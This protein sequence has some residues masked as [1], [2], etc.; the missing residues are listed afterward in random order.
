MHF[1]NRQS[2]DRIS[3]QC[4]L[5][6]SLG[7][8][9]CS[10]VKA[11]EAPPSSELETI[12]VFAQ[13]PL[14]TRRSDAFRSTANGQSLSAD[15]LSEPGRHAMGNALEKLGG[16][17]ASDATG[18]PFQPDWF[19]R[20]YS[21]SPLLG[22]PQGL[23][24]YQD[25]VRVNE[26]FGDVV[27][28]D[29]IPLVALRSADLI[30]GS[31]PV[32]GRNTLAGALSL[33]TKSGFDSPGLTMELSGGE[34]GRRGGSMEYGLAGERAAL[35]IAADTFAEDG[36]RDYSNSRVARG[37]VRGS[38]LPDDRSTLD[39]SFSGAH[40]RLRGN[41]AAPR[42]LLEQE[43]RDAVFTYPDQTEPDLAFVNLTGTRALENGARLSGNA[44]YR[45]SLTRA[46]NGDG[47]EFEECEDPANVS[48]GG[49]PYL[50]EAEDDEEEVVTD[51]DLDPVVASLDNDS[52]TQNRSR[53]QQD[54]HGLSMQIERT[55]G[56]HSLLAGL[57]ADFGDVH[58]TSDTELGRLTAQRGTVG[59]GIYVAES[60]VNVRADN[61]SQGLYL[62]DVWRLSE[63]MQI[64]AA[65]RWNRTV[66]ELKDQM[67]D[68]DLSGKH[69]FN[70]INP[71][72]GA[73]YEL[74]PNWIVFGS[75][76]QSTR[77]P[78]PVELTCANPDD[79]CRLPN[80]FVDDPPLDEVV[81]HTFE[82]G[83]RQA[84]PTWSGSVALFSALSRDDIIFITNGDLTN[85]GYF[86]N[87]GRTLRQGFEM[88]LEWTLSAHWQA[89]LQYTALMAEFRDAFLVNAPNH[90]L[91][92]ASG[93]A[94]PST[95]IVRRG[96]R[97]PLIPRQQG[98]LALEWSDNRFEFGAEMLGRSNSRFRG[99]ES[100]LD[101]DQLS[102]FVLVNINAAWKPTKLVTFF[103]S[104]DNLF[105]RD[106]ETFG[107]Y[108]EG[109]EVLGD[110]FEDA[111]RFVGAGNP[112]SVQGGVRLR[113]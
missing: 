84:N 35:Y 13:S 88:G 6:M 46:F 60:L 90:P 44:Y 73:T 104:V 89:S 82:L 37:F 76:A 100:N 32:F 107:V 63:A 83:L 33:T 53:T 70:R 7:A 29:L 11:A 75:A 93:E 112:V 2:F 98:R 68:G 20:G 8:L 81:T 101:N 91:R 105:D 102:G 61:D 92:D 41:G 65:A 9:A 23:A 17:F 16:V 86:D 15:D 62:M 27:N 56:Q 48:A 108:G 71:M 10:S 94:D 30:P 58:F 99:D 95:Q 4:G 77:A 51:L 42:E 55:F 85:A 113:F 80:G 66:I 14:D 103:A 12:E 1:I 36:W 19:Y 3:R 47:T 67:P 5:L 26:A 50:C 18:S 97:I 49:D 54:V 106:F 21:V 109:D 110:E 24:V 96:N 43:G 79:P 78:T 69:Q 87:V 31:N 25:G 52:A 59:S 74:S 64:T 39:L 40:N 45:R 28:F 57:S 38:W 111:Y 34:F 72:L 22:L